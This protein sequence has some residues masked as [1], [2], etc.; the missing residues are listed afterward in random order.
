MYSAVPVSSMISN[1]KWRMYMKSSGHGLIWRALTFDVAVGGEELRGLGVRQ[2]LDELH[3]GG[4]EVVGVAPQRRREV[5]VRH[6]PEHVALGGVE[7][8]VRAVAVLQQDQSGRERKG[9][10]GI[11]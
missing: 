8:L 11:L 1:K 7:E 2:R 4:V 9:G 6:A 5:L 10:K 3:V